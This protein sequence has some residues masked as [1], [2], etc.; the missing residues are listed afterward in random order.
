MSSVG[1]YSG[2]DKGQGDKGQGRT[3]EAAQTEG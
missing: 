3:G 2:E 1:M